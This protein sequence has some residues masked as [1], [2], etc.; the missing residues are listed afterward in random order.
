MVES[1]WMAITSWSWA[2]GIVG[3]LS[4]PELGIDLVSVV[5]PQFHTDI[6]VFGAVRMKKS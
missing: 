3:C 2:L 1:D 6:S 5:T 4:G